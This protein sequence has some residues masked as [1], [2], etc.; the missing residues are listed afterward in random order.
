MLGANSDS[1]KCQQK[2][3]KKKTSQNIRSHRSERQCDNDNRSLNLETKEKHSVQHESGNR[4]RCISEETTNSLNMQ[5]EGQEG[6]QNRKGRH[7][8][9]GCRGR[10]SRRNRSLHRAAER[11]AVVDTTEEEETQSRP[12]DSDA[13]DVHNLA[14]N[15]RV[16][17]TTQSPAKYERQL[18]VSDAALDSL[19]A[20]TIRGDTTHRRQ[21]SDQVL[22]DDKSMI[23]GE[24][25]KR[26]SL[27]ALERK[28]VLSSK[29]R[30]MDATRQ[31]HNTAGIPRLASESSDGRAQQRSENSV[32]RRKSTA[33]QQS[34]KAHNSK[35][36]CE[37]R[38][39]QEDL[40]HQYHLQSKE[41]SRMNESDSSLSTSFSLSDRSI[42][43][44]SLSSKSS[45]ERTIEVSSSYS[46]CD[47]VDGRQVEREVLH[48]LL[49]DAVVL[50]DGRTSLDSH[51]SK[52]EVTNEVKFTTVSEGSLPTDEHSS[53]LNT[54]VAIQ[55]P[56]QSMPH[57][58]ELN[59]L[60]PMQGLQDQ[61]EQPECNSSPLSFPVRTFSRLFCSSDLSSVVGEDVDLTKCASTSSDRTRKERDGSSLFSTS[62]KSFLM[63]ER[64]KKRTR[65]ANEMERI[66]TD[67]KENA[68]G[69]ADSGLKWCY[70][71]F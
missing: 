70:R 35:A 4:P 55:A 45:S 26:D 28:P 23:F 40:R 2:V 30:S 56:S 25:T 46:F 5:D 58:D 68:L 66:L 64:K 34:E 15:K 52:N 36:Y 21:K 16:G 51:S 65:E 12:A 69:I 22:R 54:C 31:H 47:D 44:V 24:S 27:R 6:Q 1:V 57:L 13:S 18:F 3:L 41:Y 14:G 48:I 9:R 39:V 71:W 10:G 62:P 49:E 17:F 60:P 43:A 32:V 59:I 7:R 42:A 63:G 29:D 50:Q 11:A 53:Q 61:V 37:T 19:G 38:S 8:P 20:A 33:Y 67:L